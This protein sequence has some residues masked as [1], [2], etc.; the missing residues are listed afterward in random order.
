VKLTGG[1]AYGVQWWLSGLINN[2]NA[3][4]STGFQYD[5]PFV[6]KNGNADRTRA[7]LGGAS[8]QSVTGGSGLFYSFLNKNF[9]VALDA[10]QRNSQTKVLSTPSL[11]V[12]N[13]QEAQITVGSQVSV[14]SQSLYNNVAPT[15]NTTTGN[16]VNST[17]VGTA[18]YI[19]TGVTL[20]I[21]PRVNP[22]G[23][24]Y[25]EVNQEDTTPNY[26]TVTPANPNPSIDQRNLKTQIAVQ[27]GETVL[28][29]GMI[30]DTEGEAKTGVPLLGSIPLIG[31]LFGN[32]TKSRDRT[33]LIV[34]I[35]P[36]VITNIDEAREM[37]QEYEQKFESLKPLQAK[38][39]E[40]KPA[41]APTP[42][43]PAP[44]SGPAPAMQ[45]ATPEENH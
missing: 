16:T 23:L 8:P 43:Q 13:N 21:T 29:G 24:V 15:T 30:S 44:Q 5:P 31:G 1:L 22:G 25:M 37:T 3:G 38:Q 35:T 34:L 32:T 2:S 36:R 10:L 45:P 18:S 4:S 39:A 27:S 19:S 28:L 41:G 12:M 7:M 17:G 9:Q 11:V 33:E 6:S 26:S 42:P 20:D 14:I 40:A